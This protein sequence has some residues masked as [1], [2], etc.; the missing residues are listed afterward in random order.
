M[1]VNVL[2][3]AQDLGKMAASLTAESIKD[4]LTK[5][6][7][8]R[9]V[10]STGAS[11]FETLEALVKMDVDWSKVE[12][13]HLDEY[14]N[15]S[16]EHPASFRKYLKE[17]FVN[18]VPIQMVHFVN[19][20][21]DIQSNIKALTE[22]IRKEP[23]DLALIGI[24]E[25]GHIAFND[26]PADFDTK[27]AYIVVDLDENCKKQQV[28]EGWFSTIEDVPKQA[29]T[30]TV[31]QIMQSNVIISCVPHKVKANAIRNLFEN[32]VT[33]HIPSTILK[34]HPN[35]N[36]FLDKQSSSEVDKQFV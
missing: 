23:I 9:L 33:N 35:F 7:K 15:L 1:K 19:G 5:Q 32:E 2:E 30:M 22:E 25:N 21:G 16:E 12:M 28:G 3:T 31:H 29:I 27:E 11:Q 26:P 36:L 10:L 20:E 14:V 13:F 18:L 8:V 24:G 4:L 6:E 34:T 17:R